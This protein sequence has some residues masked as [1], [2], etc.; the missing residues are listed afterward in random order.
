M[1]YIKFIAISF[2]VLLLLITVISFMI[3]KHVRIARTINI[4][5]PKDSVMALIK[6][7][8][9]WM[10]WYPGGE[11]S[12][13]LVVNGEIKGIAFNDDPLNPV[14]IVISEVKENEVIAGFVPG[15]MNTVINNW[16]ITESSEPGT[17][18]L[19]WRMDFDLRW[20]PW[21][22]FSSLLLEKTY[23]LP[24]EE[25]LTNIKNNVKN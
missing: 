20:Y 8:T 13:P 21:E 7:P 2:I 22:K 4:T 25:G 9:R 14:Y 10:V 12:H 1:R 17:F 11:K 19:Q 16:S 3:P 5:A 23:G 6:D 24:M 18:T 15:K